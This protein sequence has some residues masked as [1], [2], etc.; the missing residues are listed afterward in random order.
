M[1]YALAKFNTRMNRGKGHLSFL[2]DSFKLFVFYGGFVLIMENWLGVR[3]PMAMG[4][5]AVL[6][7]YLACYVVGLV[8]QRYGFW[9]K[10]AEYTSQTL[11]PFFKK[12]DEKVD[13]LLEK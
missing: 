5:F 13:K 6:G 2:I 9:L 4:I 11:N 3:L 8:D 10:E 12:L 7:Y 1:R